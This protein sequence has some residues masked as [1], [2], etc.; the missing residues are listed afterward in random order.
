MIL[1]VMSSEAASSAPRPVIAAA[2]LVII[3]A[4]LKAAASVFVPVLLG[5]FLAVPALP[6]LAWLR[7]RGVPGWL[8]ILLILLGLAL[9]VFGFGAFVATSVDRIT[10]LA[11]TYQARL[12]EL[13]RPWLERA[14]AE[15]LEVDKLFNLERL[16]SLFSGLVSGL[17]TLL[18]EGVLVLLITVFILVEALE[19]PRKLGVAVGSVAV[20]DRLKRAYREIQ[21]YL[22]LKTVVSAATGLFIGVWLWIQGVDMPLFWGVTAGLL[23]YI[24]NL[25]AFISAIP[26]VLLALVQIG[27]LGALGAA[28]AYLVAH[29]I[30]G[31][32]VEPQLMG[33]Q[34]GLSPL[35]VLLSLLF[36]GF[37]WGIVGALLAVPLTMVIKI[38]LENSPHLTWLG[39]LMEHAPKAASPV[40]A[41]LSPSP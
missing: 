41:P 27:P 17:A 40:P 13:A 34:L 33:H 18:S 20:H 39:K 14:R 21:H 36:W 25:G 22:F 10:E 32:L 29:F 19:F 1:G 35:T 38:V 31:N 12:E 15:G 2:A 5:F 6:A 23:N 8:A 7:R 26:P 16:F 9:L 3:V 11:P 37:V 28:A 4:G 30:I 24:P